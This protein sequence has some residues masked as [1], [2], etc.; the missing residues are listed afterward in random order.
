MVVTIRGFCFEKPA[1]NTIT[2]IAVES[3]TICLSLASSQIRCVAAPSGASPERDGC[4]RSTRDPSPDIPSVLLQSPDQ[5][6]CGANGELR[7]HVVLCGAGLIANRGCTVAFSLLSS[8]AVDH[9]A[10]T[11][12]P[13]V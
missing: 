1:Q 4:R 11:E 3:H 10:P 2:S 12:Y 13:I 8:K 5:P 6:I 7:R 9:A